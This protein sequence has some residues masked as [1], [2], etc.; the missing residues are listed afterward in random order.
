MQTDVSLFLV[1]WRI[2][3]SFVFIIF[4][5]NFWPTHNDSLIFTYESIVVIATYLL[6]NKHLFFKNT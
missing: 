3:I 5:L 1:I 6:F 2:F 4:A